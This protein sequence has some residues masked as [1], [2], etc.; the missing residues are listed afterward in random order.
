MSDQAITL[1][2]PTES[3]IDCSF[4]SDSNIKFSDCKQKEITS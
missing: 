3:S 4:L 2:A 1:R